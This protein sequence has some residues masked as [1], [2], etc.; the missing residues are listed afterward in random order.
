MDICLI[1]VAL[2]AQLARRPKSQI[3]AVLIADIEKA[4]ALKKHT[5]PKIK[6]PKE[7]AGL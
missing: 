7:T 2:L 6:V 5:D 3:F 1:G 4:L